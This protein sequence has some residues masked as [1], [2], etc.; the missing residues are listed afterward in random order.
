[1]QEDDSRHSAFEMHSRRLRYLE[2]W[3]EL[4]IRPLETECHPD[5]LPMLQLQVDDC[6]DL[7]NR[8]LRVRQLQN[9]SLPPH[10]LVLDDDLFPD[11]SSIA[12]AGM[13]LYSSI[14]IQKGQT[15]CYSC[16][17]IHNFHS[18]RRLGDTSYLMLVA[19]DVFVDS[20]S[21]PQIKAR[22]I[23]DPLNDDYVNCKFLPEPKF[24]RCAV[25]ATRDIQ[26]G[27]ELFVSYGDAY[28]SNR[29]HGG[30]IY[31]GVKTNS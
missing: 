26:C 31:T 25:V 7:L 28:W 27:E 8:C 9:E 16:G 22:Y 21:L 12:N 3:W 13:G 19:G 18:S 23:N 24:H 4:A 2:L 30:S 10:D 17:H 5:D 15:I 6:S 1:M 14:R 20:G 11:K 29:A